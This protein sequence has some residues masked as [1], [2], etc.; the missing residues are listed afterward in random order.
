MNSLRL[1]QHPPELIFI[2]FISQHYVHCWMLPLVCPYNIFEKFRILLTFLYTSVILRILWKSANSR[3]HEQYRRRQTTIFR[4]HEIECVYNTSLNVQNTYNSRAYWS[5]YYGVMA[6]DHS[7]K[8]YVC[9]QWY[10]CVKSSSCSVSQ[11]VNLIAIPVTK[12][13]WGTGPYLWQ[14]SILM[15]SVWGI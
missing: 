5:K 7:H 2:C 1:D 13:C 3:V 14:S 15:Y 10:T 4:S 6:A 9:I 12:R 11:N 8:V